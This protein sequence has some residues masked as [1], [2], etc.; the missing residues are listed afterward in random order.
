M[1]TYKIF[2]INPGSTSTKIALFE[3]D[4]MLFTTNI[5]HEA[6]ELKEFKEVADQFEYRKKAIIRVLQNNNISISDV[7]AFVGRGGAI[8]YVESGTWIVNEKMLQDLKDGVTGQHPANLGGPLAA[9]FANENN[10]KAYIVDPPA[11]DEFEELS[12]VTGIVD[13]TRRSRLHALNQ[14]ETARRAS[15]ELG[16]SYGELNLVVAHMGGGISVAAHRNGRIIDASDCLRGD[17]PFAPNRCGALAAGEMVDLCFSGKYNK[18]EILEK[19]SKNGGM[20]DHLGTSDVREVKE[21]IGKGNKYA[22][23]IYNAMIYQIGKEIGAYGTA[24]NGKVDAV[25][26]TGGM[27]YDIDM[28][29]KLKEMI[30]YL[31]PIRVYPGEFEM[32]ALASGVLRVLTEEEEVKIYT[33]I[34]VWDGFKY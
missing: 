4:N 17:G 8:Q 22:E 34:P 30:S 1:N 27:A 29:A 23:L 15:K 10:V 26:L 2:A 9:V 25:I 6:S 13:L 7:D 32:E 31:A 19:I 11:T 28:I 20:V 12:R 5:T 33:G 21:M 24:L 3:N 14:K 16:K 18:N